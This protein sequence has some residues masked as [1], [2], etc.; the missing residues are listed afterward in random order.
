MKNLTVA[1]LG[2]GLYLWDGGVDYLLNIANILEYVDAN[3]QEYKINIYLVLPLEH[4]II[5]KIRGWLSKGKR[6]DDLRLTHTSEYLCTN[7]K[8]VTVVYYR[9]FVKKIYNDKGRS[10]QKTLQ[11]INADICF[12]VLRN[13]YPQ[14]K[15]P[16]I[17]YI[18]DFQEKY[19]PELFDDKTRKY[20]DQNN[21]KM[22]CNTRF[23]L[24]T[25]KSVKDDMETFYPGDYKVFPQ[26]FAPVISEQF[27]DT[28]D[29][30]ISCYNL[31]QYYFVVSNQFWAHK[32]HITAFKALKLLHESGMRSIHIVCTGKMDSDNRK[33]SYSN[34][35]RQWVDEKEM[36]AYIHFLGYIPK[37]DQVEIMKHAIAIL[38]PTLFEGYPGGGV[39][40]EGNALLIPV[41]MSDIRVN[42]EADGCESITLFKAEDYQDLAECMRNEMKK[43]RENVILEKVVVR[44]RENV[45]KLA[46]FYVNMIEEVIE[47]YQPQKQK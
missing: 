24:A 11:K 21:K 18:A 45:E 19:L 30:D 15:T 31:P 16:W 44:N 28:S 23:F 4:S 10:L 12:P 43:E 17:G 47:K 26:P 29:C 36:D 40:K 3:W 42:Q 13:Y 9:K 14:I 41:I 7:C 20:R 22:V 37:K 32:A 33:E 1:L 5:R 35:L 27:W 25:S 38:Q 6:N 2:D 8:K 34:E 46:Q 39:V